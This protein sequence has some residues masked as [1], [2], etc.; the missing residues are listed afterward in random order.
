[1][2]DQLPNEVLVQICTYVIEPHLSDL[3][4]IGRL[5]GASWTLN[6]CVRC[7]IKALDDDTLA[8]INFLKSYSRKNTPAD[9]YNINNLFGHF[10]KRYCNITRA[11]ITA[12]THTQWTCKHGYRYVLVFTIDKILYSNIVCIYSNIPHV[13]PTVTPNWWTGYSGNPYKLYIK[14]WLYTYGS[15]IATLMSKNEI[16]LSNTS[17]NSKTECIKCIYNY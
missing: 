10:I 1:M 11:Y 15:Y 9:Y 8:F 17:I 6:E 7:A 2:L 4:N 3:A 14:R 12:V 5:M 13:E 16:I